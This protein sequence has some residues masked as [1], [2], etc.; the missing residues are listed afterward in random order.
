MLQKISCNDVTGTGIY[1]SKM[2][3]RKL[4]GGKKN[5]QV[6][7][8]QEFIAAIPPHIQEKSSSWCGIAA[9]SNRG[10]EPIE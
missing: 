3:H 7:T 8:V 10:R 9:E 4:K 6:F 5:F 1:K 2:L